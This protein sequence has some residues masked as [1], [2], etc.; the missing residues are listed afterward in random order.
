VQGRVRELHLRLDADRAADAETSGRF[1]R[2][3]EQRRLAYARLAAYH[4]GTALP[5]AHT[6]DQTIERFTL[7]AATQ[8][9]LDRRR[10]YTDRA[11]EL[12]MP[13]RCPG[14][15]FWER[16]GYHNYGDPWKEPRYW[17]D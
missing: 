16:Y 10:T 17:G 4:E 5:S 8:E 3:L 6:V 9:H 11:A 7:A 2:V 13:D 12:R 1:D 15:H 14:L